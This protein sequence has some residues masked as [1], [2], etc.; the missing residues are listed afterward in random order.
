MADPFA[1]G[2]KIL[3][4]NW[5]AGYGNLAYLSMALRDP[6]ELAI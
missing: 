1:I 6:P 4:Q 3:D 2:C 5:I